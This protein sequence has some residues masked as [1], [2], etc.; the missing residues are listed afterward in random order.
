MV[1]LKQCQRLAAR[2]GNGQLLAVSV[3]QGSTEGNQ[4]VLCIE[5]L[6]LHATS[7]FTAVASD[8]NGATSRHQLLSG[9]VDFDVATQV[10]GVQADPVGPV[11][12]GVGDHRVAIAR[13]FNA[14]EA[15]D[16]CSAHAWHLGQGEGFAD[17]LPQVDATCMT[18]NR[19]RDVEAL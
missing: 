8:N 15:A 19:A 11:G 4:I 16:F 5:Q 13:G 6:E 17:A 2:V 9:I 3:F 10:A 18:Y 1:L 12:L 14:T 7:L